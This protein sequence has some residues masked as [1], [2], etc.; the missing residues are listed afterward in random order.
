MKSAKEEILR[1]LKELQEKGVQIKMHDSFM[2]KTT[3]N[4]LTFTGSCVSG[5]S[6]FILLP[7]P[8]DI[9]IDIYINSSE[10]DIMNKI[11]S[12]KDAVKRYEETVHVSTIVE[13]LQE[14][15]K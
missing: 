7:A 14:K 2:Q 6:S 3:V 1:S 12:S 13:F 4:G 9:I 11:I 10:E 15:L 5:S 8:K